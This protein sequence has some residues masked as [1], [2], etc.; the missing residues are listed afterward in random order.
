M[1]AEQEFEAYWTA[2]IESRGPVSIGVYSEAKAAWLA[3]A[4]R[5]APTDA[6]FAGQTVPMDEIE[7]EEEER[8]RG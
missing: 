6:E 5:Y 7:A 2:G 1:S 8:Q 3:A 4:K